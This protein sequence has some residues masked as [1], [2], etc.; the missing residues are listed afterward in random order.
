[1]FG[2][3]KSFLGIK[4]KQLGQEIIEAIVEID[5][6]GA[7]QA[8]LEQMEQDLDK[9]G[10][11]LQK[12][13]VDYEREVREAEEATG[14]YDKMLAAAEHLQARLQNPATPVS[15]HASI[16]A[17]LTRLIG[18]IEAFTHDVEQEKQDVVEVK[19]LLEEAGAAYKVKAAALTQAKHGIDRA[20][21]DMQR[22]T[23]QVERAEEKARRAAEVAGLRGGGTNKLSIATEAMQR[24]AEKARSRAA[25]LGMKA[26]ALALAKPGANEDP[27]IAD[28]LRAIEN[29]SGPGG[30]NLA[31]RLAALQK[32]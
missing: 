5:P 12:I 24:K 3:M 29:K 23:L 7:T 22:V 17:S 2:F 25:A 16:E 9:A 6:E 14:R 13:R 27:L 8:Q 15:E 26:E 31:D 28:A 32:K 19:A 1:M 18:Q 30:V 21:H 20:K 11:V 4:G 10:M